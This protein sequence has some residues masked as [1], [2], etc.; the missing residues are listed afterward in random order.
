MASLLA[1][2]L[3]LCLFQGDILGSGFKELVLNHLFPAN[4]L[5]SWVAFHGF[6]KGLP[7]AVE[8]EAISKSPKDSFKFS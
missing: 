8:A 7:F 3:A 6:P 2:A 4:F 1:A 5:G